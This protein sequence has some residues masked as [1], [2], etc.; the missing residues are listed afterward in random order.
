MPPLSASRPGGGR[1]LAQG[2][3]GRTARR[4]SAP[5]CDGSLHVGRFHAGERERACACVLHSPLSAPGARSASPSG[6]SASSPTERSWTA[7]SPSARAPWHR[8][9]RGRLAESGASAA[10]PAGPAP[11]WHSPSR[12][13]LGRH[14]GAPRGG[15]S[16][17]NE[18]R[19]PATVP[20]LPDRLPKDEWRPAGRRF[21]ANDFGFTTTPKRTLPA[22]EDAHAAGATFPADLRACRCSGRPPRCH[23]GR[24]RRSLRARR[25]RRRHGR[26]LQRRSSRPAFERASFSFLRASGGVG[27][28]TA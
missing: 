22:G 23:R 9:S 26:T 15:L 24:R 20:M 25:L 5:W 11:G 10:R 17:V 6:C 14:R 3:R 21:A 1:L 28:L 7:A 4:A 18:H 16:V 12:L 19:H 2:R 27:M 8:R 13:P